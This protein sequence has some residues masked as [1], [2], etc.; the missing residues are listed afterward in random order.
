MKTMPTQSCYLTSTQCLLCVCDTG[1]KYSKI[2]ANR[3]AAHNFVLG[4][5]IMIIVLAITRF[6]EISPSADICI[7]QLHRLH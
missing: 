4:T 2:S 1:M 7:L 6:I 5:Y 3:Y